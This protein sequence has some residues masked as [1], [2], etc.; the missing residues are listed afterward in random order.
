MRGPFQ[1]I[2]DDSIT[3][4]PAAHSNSALFNTLPLR[5]FCVES[6][7]KHQGEH[8]VRKSLAFVELGGWL[9]GSSANIGVAVATLKTCGARRGRGEGGKG[10][11]RK[12]KGLV[13][14]GESMAGMGDPL[15]A[16]AL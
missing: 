11:E 6:Y 12:L 4:Y 16:Q 8:G 13:S 2:L 5:P 7:E 3:A 15:M 1:S 14:D 10:A 9:E